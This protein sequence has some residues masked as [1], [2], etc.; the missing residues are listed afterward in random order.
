[1]ALGAL[2]KLRRAYTAVKGLAKPVAG[3][4]KQ[5]A[6]K[7]KSAVQGLASGAKQLVT[8]GPVASTLIKGGKLIAPSVAGTAVVGGT[9]YGLG[10]KGAEG[11]G[12]VTP[13]QFAK[14]ESVDLLNY[15]PGAGTGLELQ[16]YTPIDR[17]NSL[18]LNLGNKDS[19]YSE[20][21]L[22]SLAAT[23]QRKAIQSS[24]EA[25]TSNTLIQKR[26]KTIADMT[27]QQVE[28]T[29][30]NPETGESSFMKMREGENQ[31][32]YD[33]RLALEKER[34][35]KLVELANLPDGQGLEALK[36]SDVN[37]GT[38]EIQTK[39]QQ[40]TD[41]DYANPR[42]VNRR[43]EEVAKQERQTSKERYRDEQSLLLQKL[44]ADSNQTQG[45]FA[46]QMAQ[47]NY[48]NRALDMREARES[49]KDKQ[50]MIMQLMKGLSEMGRSFSY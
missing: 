2:N 36:N 11:L 49:R 24:D 47:Q 3:A 19:E 38:D 39:I 40:V 44:I 10:L 26:G 34:L 33:Q 31:A 41:T 22:A 7:G 5:V 21:N 50:L 30:L 23:N 16:N 48:N 4:T 13:D 46:V 15:R 9:L 12:L 45:Q 18:I 20:Q 32:K 43:A 29:S 1:M 27:G 6:T 42:N 35:A 28:S 14:G 25:V 8:P 37:M 17:L